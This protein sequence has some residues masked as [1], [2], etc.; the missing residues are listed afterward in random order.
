MM[1][2]MRHDFGS[3]PLPND[4]PVLRSRQRIL[5]L[6]SLRRS[7][8]TVTA[9]SALAAFASLAAARSLPLPLSGACTKDVPL[10]FQIF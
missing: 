9:S 7:T 5:K 3:R 8:P 2:F 1:A 6:V 4:I 10:L